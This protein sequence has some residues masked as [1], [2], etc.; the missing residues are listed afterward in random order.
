LSVHAHAT[1]S[2]LQ[3][4]TVYY[5]WQRNGVDISGATSA[6]YTTSFLTAADDGA[7]YRVVIRTVEGSA[8]V[9]EAVVL[10]V[11]SPGT[12]AYLQISRRTDGKAVISW[13]R[14][15]YLLQRT[16]N[17][18]GFWEAAATQVSPSVFA[19]SES[20]EFFRLIRNR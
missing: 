16:E 7:E 15:D 11:V 4:G 19:P 3:E 17:V 2:E 1:H 8:A 13:E 20:R 6:F 18:P 9:S 10:S 14:S 12:P 5:Q